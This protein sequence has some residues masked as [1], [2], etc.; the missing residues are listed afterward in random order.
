MKHAGDEANNNP[1]FKLSSPTRL[2]IVNW[3]RRGYVFPQESKAMIQR[4]FYAA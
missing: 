3:V 1:S 2:D 4:F